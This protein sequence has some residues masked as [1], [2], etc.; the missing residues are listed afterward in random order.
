MI[1]EPH[2]KVHYRM[3]MPTI[4][5]W[6]VQ[7]TPKDLTTKYHTEGSACR[8]ENVRLD[9]LKTGLNLDKIEDDIEEDREGRSK[10][11]VDGK[12]SIKTVPNCKNIF[13][14]KCIKVHNT[15][16]NT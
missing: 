11:K 15:E 1:K 16:Q 7:V 12:S 8:I 10:D 5:S 13:D 4:W 2:W 6:I 14:L 9:R 3:R